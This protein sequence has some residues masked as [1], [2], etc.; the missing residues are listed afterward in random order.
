[1]K[2][3]YEVNFDTP[4]LIEESANRINGD[5][6]IADMVYEV[7][8][9]EQKTEGTKQDMDNRTHITQSSTERFV[10]KS[11]PSHTTVCDIVG[12]IEKQTSLTR[13]TIVA[14]LQK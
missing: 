9:G 11:N 5:L 7:K 1:M 10:L 14:I 6:Y 2:T 8:T 3:I 12:E 4:Q 13:R